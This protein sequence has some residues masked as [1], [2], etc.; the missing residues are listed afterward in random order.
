MDLEKQG[1]QDIASFVYD[2][3]A[4]MIHD[5]ERF[6]RDVIPTYFKMTTLSSFQRQVSESMPESVFC[7]SAWSFGELHYVKPD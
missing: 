4:F 5:A 2:G 3:R 6:V 7:L 1:R